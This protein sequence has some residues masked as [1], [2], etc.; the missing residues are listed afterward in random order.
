MI[1]S[2]FSKREKILLFLTISFAVA[3]LSYN[4]VFHPMGLNFETLNKEILTKE[5]QLRK[6][7]KILSQKENIQNEYMEYS[8]LLR[9]K[10]SNEQEMATLLSEIE[11]V[12]REIAIRITDMKPRAIRGIDFYNRLAVDVEVEAK[13]SEITKFI[14]KKLI[15]NV[16]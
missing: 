14:Y 7:V 16:I 15:K 4:F 13:L 6:N 2:D 1:F 11:S 3:F 12:A 8:Q 10:S 5:M 9:Q